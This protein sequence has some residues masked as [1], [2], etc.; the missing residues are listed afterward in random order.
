TATAK[1]EAEVGGDV[2]VGASVALNIATNN[3][4][5][6][7]IEDTTTITGATGN[8]TMTATSDHTM[9]TTAE[10]GSAGDVSVSPSVAISIVDN[11][12][13]A[14][15]GLSA[16][17]LDVTG[18]VEVRATHANTVTT[19]ADSQ[20]VGSSVGVGV[21]VGVAVVEDDVIATTARTIDAD[22]G[23]S[24][25][26]AASSDVSSTVESKASAKGNKSSDSGGRSADDEADHQVNTNQHTDGQTLPSA[27]SNAD[28][29]NNTSNSNSSTG[30][31]S[32]GVAAAVSVN[33]VTVDNTASIQ[34]GVDVF[35]GA[36][37]SV[38]AEAEVDA[39]AKALGS[40]VELS[41]SDNIGAAVGLNVANVTN[42]AFVGVGSIV[43]GDGI[44]IEAVTIDNETNEFIVWG[45]AAAGGTGDVGVAGSVGINVVNVTTEA[46]ARSGSDLESTGGLTVA[47]ENDM[48]IQ[49]LAAGGGFSTGTAVGAAVSIGIVDSSTMAF[50][51][52]DA[53]AA[54]AMSVT[55]ET[56]LAPITFSQTLF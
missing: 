32:V 15:I 12:T 53:D 21:A 1:A 50:I 26:I 31:S 37:V 38:S 25:T 27:Q 16:N 13:T 14:R 8:V 9:T 28:S 22:A 17:T 51:A 43:E 40:A 18:N 39:T 33:V 46:S 45:V 7:E 47:A 24:V 2:G 36:A 5:R 49:T 6:A 19:T 20:A 23:G 34:D 42:T 11:D 29:A 48:A 4:T 44:T 52:G 35:A 10:A 55:A 56:D 41:E 3:I 30:S 54:G